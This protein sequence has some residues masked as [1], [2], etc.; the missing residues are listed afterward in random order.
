MKTFL[1]IDYYAQITV[2]FGY[3]IFALIN[4]LLQN[5]FAQVWFKFYFVVG[6]F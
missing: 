6:G 5:G 3:I 4:S 1:K 2:F